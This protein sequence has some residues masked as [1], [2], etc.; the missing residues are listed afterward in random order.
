MIGLDKTSSIK[1]A[2]IWIIML[3]CS[4]TLSA[5]VLL[6]TMQDIKLQ[7]QK[8]FA[9]LDSY[10][11][12]LSSNARDSLLSNDS[13]LEEQRLNSFSAVNM[14]HNLHV[15]KWQPATEQFDFFA[16]YN[17]REVGPHP[18]QFSRLTQLHKPYVSDNHIELSKPLMQGTDLL[19]Y[20]YMRVSRK[21]QSAYIQ[22]RI[23]TDII[24][25][26]IALSL[27]F[28]IAQ[29]LQKKFTAPLHQLLS[30][31]QRVA[32]DKDYQLR[33]TAAPLHEYNL[34]SRAFNT[35]LDRIEQQLLKRQEAEQEI[36]LLNQQLEHK[37]TERTK[38]LKASNQ[39][40]LD[41]LAKLHQ[42][43]SQIVQTE[44]M[45]SLG[46]MVAGVAHE[47]NTPIGLGVTASTLMQDK[48]QEIQKS[49]DD[50]NL[51][52]S[53]LAKFLLDSKENLGII[54]RNLD[55][56]ASL[57]SSFKQVAVDQS[58][59]NRRQFNMLQ[60]INEVLLS[61]RPNLKKTQHIIN[62]DCPANLN[63][64]S[65]P[66]PINQIFIN[67][68]MNSLIHAFEQQEQGEITIQVQYV[69][70]NCLIR[71]CDNGTGVPENIKKRI[72]DP[73]VTTKRGAGGSGL[74]MH[75]V[76]NL[77]TQALHGKI[78]LESTLGQGIE[79]LIEFPVIDTSNTNKT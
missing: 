65:K 16:S 54:Y 62:V 68:I 48:L 2:L 74:G 57:I 4:L 73:F 39:E 37:I 7:Q 59:D 45:S 27:A 77:V 70:Q 20:V 25:I 31:M 75:L 61:L 43:Q 15:Y 76:Y 8:L 78:Q 14:I 33:A 56:A 44:K 26:V 72:F 1:S 10:L 24:I 51:T 42:Y 9:E 28:F 5:A 22:N 69:Q 11:N 38:A 12:I 13:S 58:N 32:K 52:A 63:I 21:E 34:L 64:D 17:H 29:A 67:L 60:L 40:L 23:V 66:G 55:R 47:V 35:M 19:G 79:I 36:R 30:L 71:Y 53:Q 18:V 49:F 3:V 50:K 6:S 41:T 46:Q